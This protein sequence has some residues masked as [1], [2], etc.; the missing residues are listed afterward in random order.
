MI[1]N[2]HII[3]EILHNSKNDSLLELK[4]GIAYEH[5]PMDAVDLISE[6]IDKLGVAGDQKKPL[7]G[8]E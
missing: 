7:I 6:V 3:G 8:I 2:K 4:V 1:P 5:N